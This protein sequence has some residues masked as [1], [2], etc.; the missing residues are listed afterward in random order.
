MA[1]KLACRSGI[2]RGRGQARSRGRQ[3]D[4]SSQPG[5]PAQISAFDPFKIVEKE[6]AEVIW[7]SAWVP[8]FGLQSL[9]LILLIAAGRWRRLFGGDRILWSAARVVFVRLFYRLDVNGRENI[10]D[11]RTGAFGLQPRQLHRLFAF[12]GP[13][14]IHP[15]RDLRRLDKSF[16]HSP[17]APLGPGHSIDA[18]PAPRPCSVAPIA[19]EALNET[20][21]S[22]SS[23]KADSHAPV[24]CCR[25]TAASSRSSRNQAPIIP[26]CLDEL[27]G[28]IFSFYGDR[29]LWKWPDEFPYPRLLPSASRCRHLNRRRGA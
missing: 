1:E 5:R 10:P 3:A 7:L 19:G 23:P 25:F 18:T 27:W 17:S 4:H 8:L 14:A 29:T 2:S 9:P 6:I 24:S 21:W 28:S 16:V 15:L 13:A 22:A 20:I 26:V 12:G 11:S